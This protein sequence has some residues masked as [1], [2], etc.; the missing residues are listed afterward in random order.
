MNESIGGTPEP[1]YIPVIRR[2]KPEPFAKEPKDRFFKIPIE[3]LIKE[4]NKTHIDFALSQPIEEIIE[5]LENHRFSVI[6]A[7][8]RFGKS[9]LGALLI[10]AKLLEPN[11]NIMV[12]APKYSNSSVIWE[13]V[14]K[15]IKALGLE[16][17]TLNTKNWVL[18]LKRTGSTLRLGAT[19]SRDSLVGRGFHF[20]I[21]DEA[22]LID[23]DKYYT[24]DLRPTLSTY[25]N[26]RIMFI[27]TPRGKHNYLYNYYLR[28]ADETKK[29]WSSHMFKWWDNPRAD[30]EDIDEARDTSD[31]A[32][33]L[34]EYECVWSTF[35]GQI[36]RSLDNTY[37]EEDLH[38]KSYTEY[39]AGIDPGFRDHTAFILFGHSVET[40]ISHVI[41]SFQVNET[42]F[43][44]IAD[45][46]H[47]KL[48]DRIELEACYTDDSAP[49]LIQALNMRNI[50]AIGAKKGK[51]KEGISTVQ[52]LIK[53]RK[54]R[55]DALTGLP[56]YNA[57][58]SYTWKE[59][60]LV[61]R[62]KHDKHSHYADALRYALKAHT[63]NNVSDINITI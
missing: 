38:T 3:N 9:Y 24:R 59:N 15:F 20:I 60:D 1:K 22:S 27:S 12:V 8:R 17:E 16:I 63:E 36:Y 14:V 26:S 28:G 39:F 46:I 53:Q 18:K 47:E 61:G 51:V 37:L 32:E 42:D 50:P 35:I 33:F 6:I 52:T 49:D 10:V 19:T 48:E 44:T 23:D 13:E 40:G 4:I 54:I 56:V 29:A 5:S 2:E 62:P 7:A 58:T 34:Q 57:L 43:D 30:K 21:V 11:T 45:L 55:F 31:E 25:P 41:D